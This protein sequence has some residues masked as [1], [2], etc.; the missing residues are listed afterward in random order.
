MPAT[1]LIVDD[2]DVVRES[3]REW[4]GIAFPGC[5]VIEAA[6]GE[7]AVDLVSVERPC[8]AVMD[9]SLPE[10]SGIEA[11]RRIKAAAP[12]VQVVMLTIHD[13]EAYRRDAAA[14]GA[15]AFV[16][17]PMMQTALVPTLAALLEEQEGKP[18]GAS[19]LT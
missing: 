3:L 17:K 13:S 18:L 14:A 11:T 5:R 16:P 12:A 2:H 6:S 1:I 9:I 4:L 15:S 19:F 8:I 10:M 7:A